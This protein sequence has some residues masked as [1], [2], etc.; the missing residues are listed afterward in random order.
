MCGII[1]LSL[2][3]GKWHIHLQ[4]PSI[5]QIIVTIKN[6]TDV[7]INNLAPNLYNSFSIV[8]LGLCGGSLATGIFDGGNKFISLCQQFQ[9]VISRTFFPF[10]SRKK[11][12]HSLFA[13]INISIAFVVA[14]GL[15]L[16][17]P[18]IVKWFLSNEF[19]ESIIVI[20]ILS[21]SLIFWAI[22][23][24]YGIN[25]L[26][27]QKREKIL[28]NITICGSII[29]LCIG[30]PLISQYS[31]IG[32]SITIATSRFILGILTYIYAKKD[33]NQ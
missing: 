1:S 6:S 20:R 12:K 16:S 23:D 32:A 11:D 25:Y 21:V 5:Q 27:I 18:L 24:T 30:Y 9:S 7:F 29:G 3:L 14:T 26:I 8:I 28:R 13:T 33:Y 19:N 15:F 10:L 4:Q 31:Y 2:I 22:S 17:A